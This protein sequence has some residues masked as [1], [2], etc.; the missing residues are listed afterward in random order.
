M[1]MILSEYSLAVMYIIVVLSVLGIIFFAVNNED[2][3][4]VTTY[5]TNMVY[6]NDFM[7]G[8][9]LAGSTSLDEYEVSGKLDSIDGVTNKT[10]SLHKPSFVVDS[11]ATADDYIIPVPSVGSADNSTY[12]YAEALSLF[13]ANGKI[14]LTVW[15]GTSYEDIGLPESVDIVITKLTPTKRGVDGTFATEMIEARDKYGNII[16]DNGG[17][18]IMIEQVVYSE[19]SFSRDNIGD[20]FI[21]WDVACR[22]R[23]LF[24]YTDG[25][26]KSEYSAMYAN[27]IRSATEIYEE[28]Y[29]EWV[30]SE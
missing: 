26:L 21:D 1:R 19:E 22:Y 24:R 4:F 3:G 10:L 25:T 18:P 27:K 6:A 23:V 12:T 11:S 16:R 2:T 29:T 20:F 30:D 13:S 17:N 5:N 15:N 28:V 8:T 7:A 14:H 9:D